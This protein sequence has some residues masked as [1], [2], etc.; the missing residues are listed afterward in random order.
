M[1]DQDPVQVGGYRLRARLGAGG[2]GEVFLSFGASGQPVAVKVLRREFA[3]DRTFRS[4][5]GHEVRAARQVAGPGIA[6]LLDADPDAETPWLA[7]EYVAGPTLDDAVSLYGPLPV[8]AVIV[9]MS[10]IAASLATIHG[11]GI[12]HRDLKPANVVLGADGLRVIDFGIA[13]AADATPLT[14]TGMMVGSPQYVAPEQVLGEPPAAP[15]DVFSLGALAHYAATGRAA[16]GEGPKYGVVYRIVNE[17]PDLA[18][19]PR[20]IRSLIE[21]CLAKNPHE[22]PTIAEILETCTPDEPPRG[23]ADWLPEPVVF[24]IGSYQDALKRLVPTGRDEGGRGTDTDRRGGGDRVSQNSASRSSRSRA[25]A[26]LARRPTPRT[27]VVLTAALAAAAATAGMVITLAPGGATAV[28]AAGSSS[29]ATRDPAGRP[30]AGQA[31]DTQGALPPDGTPPP[32]GAAPGDG[33]PPDAP[34][35]PPPPAPT[36]VIWS[37]QIRF[38]AAGLWFDPKQPVAAQGQVHGDIRLAAPAVPAQ[39]S[40]NGPRVR[41][42]ALWTA[43]GAPDG[44]QCRDLAR[45]SGT[46]QVH[47]TAGD[48]V[49]VLTAYRQVAVVR[50]ESVPADG[51]GVTAAATIWGAAAR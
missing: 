30:A 7:T 45:T 21:S 18:G 23:A 5:F 3:D 13:R 42:L 38:T 40:S 14:L 34:G 12:V 11:A 49:C 47:V 50:I 20:Q 10:A 36:A 9:L 35:G 2:M 15:G 29:T 24:A 28:G 27:A 44:V 51:S 17:R 37:G 1:R 31:T 39:V 6:P 32:L 33:A 46:W 43:P 41:N 16:F 48:V 8:S 22:R 25:V 26:A 19:C 4:R